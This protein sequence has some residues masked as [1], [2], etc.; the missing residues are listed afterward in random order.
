MSTAT[1]RRRPLVL[2]LALVIALTTTSCSAIIDA[3]RGSRPAPTASTAAQGDPDPA[4]TERSITIHW[5]AYM[6]GGG[7]TTGDTVITRKPPVE[8][9][10]FRVEFSQD[11][12][13]GLGGQSEAGAW[14]AAIVSTLLLGQPMEGSFSFAT[15]G[16]VDGPSA[17]AL[18]TA[19]LIALARGEK[20]IDTVTMT[21]TINA[22]G[23]VG[24]VG[25]IPEKLQ[26]AA[27]AGFTKVLIPLGQRNTASSDTGEMVDTV[28]LGSQLGVEV[29]EVGDIY[30]AYTHLTGSELE[31]PG[32][33]RDPRLDDA[34]YGKISTQTQA[35][36]ARY[37]TGSDRLAR[38]PI[39]LQQMLDPFAQLAELTATRSANLAQQGLQGGAYV[40]AAQSAA[41]IEA[42]AAVGEMYMP[43][44]TQ[45]AA[46]VQT[47]LNQALDTSAAD[48]EFGSFL[49]LLTAY[50][51]K[52]VADVEGLVMGYAGAFEAYTLLQWAYQQIEGIVA[53]F[54]AGSF[55]S[56]EEMIQAATVP[57]MYSQLARS[58]LRNAASDFEI[59]R[60]NPGAPLSGDV[61][62]AVIGDFFRKGADANLNAFMSTRV[63]T[64]ADEQ[65]VSLEV[66]ANAY[67]NAD[68][69]VAIAMN[70]QNSMGAITRY[71]GDENPNQQYA[72]LAYGITNYS[73][74]QSLMDKWYNNAIKDENLAIVGARYESALARGIDLGRQ[75]LAQQINDLRASGTE[76]VLSVGLYEVA[77]L[78]R[79][80]SV[81]DQFE[82]VATYSRGFLNARMLAYVTGLLPAS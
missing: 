80:G 2:V 18:T 48:R 41:Y 57:V 21:G 74:N 26:G 29:I 4:D 33:A 50:T 10:D 69:N 15:N 20:F 54:D 11:E 16:R 22:T 64:D 76:P 65:G 1:A 8:P 67:A 6:S 73:R 81:S 70:Q 66:M 23:T 56:I 28:R 17:G 40:L 75:Q 7:G 71:I 49:D 45:G 82:A 79:S 44:F 72:V 14:N 9:G 34:S 19:G 52:T 53:A 63:Q 60:D 37:T 31:V 12:V 77:G 55:S 38:L 42:V 36:L 25:G 27:A 46:G 5:L 39:E 3:I 62:L 78:D 35:A 32:V 30:E 43:L 51:P 61:D 59:G 68:I 47:I 24:P 13:G 58:T